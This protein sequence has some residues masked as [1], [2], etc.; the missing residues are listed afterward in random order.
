MDAIYTTD[1]YPR[2]KCSL[3]IDVQSDGYVLGVYEPSG[4]R[5]EGYAKATTPRQL[6]RMV[7]EW[8]SGY[9]PKLH[10]RLDQSPSQVV[11]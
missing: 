6:A 5:I 7:E 1:D 11:T 10:Q 2:A 8:L 4:K 9:P 3:G